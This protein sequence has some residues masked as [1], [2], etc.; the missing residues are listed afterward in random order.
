MRDYRVNNERARR[1][2]VPWAERR[3]LRQERTPVYNN[4]SA[5]SLRPSLRPHFANWIREVISGES[6]DSDYGPEMEMIDAREHG[7]VSE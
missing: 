1:S 4:E 2:A 7:Y 6:A 3:A 5:G